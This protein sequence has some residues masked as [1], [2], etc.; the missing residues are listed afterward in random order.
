MPNTAYFKRVFSIASEILTIINIWTVDSFSSKDLTLAMFIASNLLTIF[1]IEFASEFNTEKIQN[2]RKFCSGFLIIFM[3]ILIF[4]EGKN[5]VNVM[6][7]IIGNIIY[8]V[9]AIFTCLYCMF[10]STRLTTHD[11]LNKSVAT[12]IDTT[13]NIINKEAEK[14]RDD[15]ETNGG[16]SEF[17]KTNIGQEF[18]QAVK[19][20][21]KSKV[22]RDHHKKKK[23]R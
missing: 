13:F 14:L 23:R 19:E 1:G 2:L 20:N 15:I 21:T 4:D 12:S 11:E 6:P 8:T 18:A 22:P 17:L 5:F 9:V 16:W 10:L 7:S 3:F